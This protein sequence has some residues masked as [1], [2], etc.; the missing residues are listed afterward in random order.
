MM[1]KQ[2]IG[3]V[4]VARVQRNHAQYIHVHITKPTPEFRSHRHT[5]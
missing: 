2:E 3:P 4:H 1:I 5:Y